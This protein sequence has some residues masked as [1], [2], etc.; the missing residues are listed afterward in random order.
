MVPKT[1]NKRSVDDKRGGRGTAGNSRRA[2][3]NKEDYR[4]GCGDPPPALL[5]GSHTKMGPPLMGRKGI[6]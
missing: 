1:G 5:R 6:G 2:Q 4:Y 3:Q